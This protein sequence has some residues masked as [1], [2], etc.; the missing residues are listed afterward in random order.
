MARQRLLLQPSQT[1]GMWKGVEAGLGLCWR[2]PAGSEG[3]GAACSLLPERPGDIHEDSELHKC[4]LDSSATVSYAAAQAG[5]FGAHA[6]CG[7]CPGPRTLPVGS[8]T[9]PCCPEGGYT[10]GWP[11]ALWALPPL[12]QQCQPSFRSTQDD[13]TGGPA[14]PTVTGPA[15]STEGPPYLSCPSQ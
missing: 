7:N 13:C 2:S 1:S 6:R 8:G 10:A 3:S 4:H 5:V 15:V 14:T 9:L 11:S 12:P